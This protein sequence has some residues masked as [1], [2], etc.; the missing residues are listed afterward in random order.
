MLEHESDL[1]EPEFKLNPFNIRHISNMLAVSLCLLTFFDLSLYFSFFPTNLLKKG[2]STPFSHKVSKLIKSLPFLDSRSIILYISSPTLYVSHVSLFG[3]S[4][5]V[6][7][8]EYDQRFASI[9]KNKD[10]SGT[11]FFKYDLNFPEKVLESL[12]GKVD[13]VVI[14]PP[15]LNEV[16]NELI[17]KSVKLLLKPPV[18]TTGEENGGKV[19]LITGVSIGDQASKYYQD[20]KDPSTLMKR[21]KLEVE[22]ESG[23]ANP[24]GAWANFDDAENWGE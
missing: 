11:Q 9:A 6:F 19:L 4:N 12:K 10:G 1:H 24:F 8:F 22:H 23:L 3:Q 5:N 17:G 13:L 18:A 14:D 16:T 2:Y 7:L 20:E 21:T 15:F